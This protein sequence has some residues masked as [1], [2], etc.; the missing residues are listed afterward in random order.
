[1][2]LYCIYGYI[3]LSSL[4]FPTYCGEGG[5]LCEPDGAR[6]LQGTIVKSNGLPL[7]TVCRISL[8]GGKQKTPVRP[9]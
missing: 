2:H 6:Q 8:A 7:L 1:M 3:W 4:S 5:E 9:L